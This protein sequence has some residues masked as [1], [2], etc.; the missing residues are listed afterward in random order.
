MPGEN[1][2]PVDFPEQKYWNQEYV[3]HKK[4]TTYN[5]VPAFNPSITLPN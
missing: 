2:A 4:K 5:Y 3:N 1:V